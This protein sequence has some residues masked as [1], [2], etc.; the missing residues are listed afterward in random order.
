MKLQ[1]K[2]PAEREND[3]Q[4]F[5]A[6]VCR[7]E[8]GLETDTA[9]AALQSGAEVSGKFEFEALLESAGLA[10]VLTPAGK[11]KI[12]ACSSALET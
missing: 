10:R 7:F 4:E 2:R 8:R 1:R 9:E 11:K 3:A 6:C 5:R 12:V